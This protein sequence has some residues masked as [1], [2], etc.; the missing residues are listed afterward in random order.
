MGPQGA[1]NEALGETGVQSGRPSLPK[2]QI[3]GVMRAKSTETL[4]NLR[5]IV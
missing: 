2:M 5:T 1:S 3:S 4:C